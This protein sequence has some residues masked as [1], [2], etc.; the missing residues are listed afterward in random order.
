LEQLVTLPP[1]LEQHQPTI[2]AELHALLDASSGSGLPLYQIMAYQLGW[3]DK[4]GTPEMGMAPVRL[5]GALCLEAA[6]L[7]GQEVPAPA[8]SAMEMLYNSIQVHEDMQVGSPHL[9]NRPAVWWEWG[10]AQAINVGDGLHALARLGAFRMQSTGATA[11]QILKSVSSLDSTALRF[12][13]GQF[14][15]LTFQERIDILESQYMKMAEAKY[16]TL[17][18]GSMALGALTNGGDD[19]TVDALRRAGELIGVAAQLTDDLRQ[20][21]SSPGTEGPAARV[22]NKSKLF[23][24]VRALETA[25][26]PQKR[27]LG[28]VYFKRVME[29]DDV[30]KVSKVVDEV[31]A[32]EYTEAKAKELRQEALERMAGVGVSGAALT[33]WEEIVDYIMGS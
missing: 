2:E 17:I 31:G 1:S 15:E 10:P 4:Q 24:V 12:Y 13:E 29:P 8:A 11:E 32:R 18:G 30:A 33:R 6:L 22:L 21:T 14:L 27:L 7:V 3:V 16:G 23:P 25:T 9:E 19:Q 5:Y 26:L 20:L 28:E